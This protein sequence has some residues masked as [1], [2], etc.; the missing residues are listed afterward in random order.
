MYIIELRVLDKKFV[1]VTTDTELRFRLYKREAERYGLAEDAELTDK[2]LADILDVL[3]KRGRERALYIIERS[4]KTEKE[5]RN[6]LNVEYY[7]ESI[8]E[9][10]INFL[11]NYNYIND[12]RYAEQYVS[13][14]I[15]GKS[16]RQ[17]KYELV[18][19]GISGEIVEEVLDE[20]DV[21]CRSVIKNILNTRRFD[22]NLSDR[23]QLDKQ[24]RYF[25]GKGFEYDDIVSVLKEVSENN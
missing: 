20:Q 10:V 4:E 12:R 14:K 1:L 17:I 5:I 3:K 22:K 13:S 24:I 18:R 11:K 21:D 15:S 23:K 6:K 16:S 7:P 8:V 25:I 9:Y 19:K 2:V